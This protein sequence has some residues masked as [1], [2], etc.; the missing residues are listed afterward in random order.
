[1]DG[2]RIGNN[3]QPTRAGELISP[4]ENAWYFLTVHLSLLV[5][6]ADDLH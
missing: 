6:M 5:L 1:M 2:K 3:T 4:Q